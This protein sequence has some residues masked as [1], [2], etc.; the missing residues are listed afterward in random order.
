MAALVQSRANGSTSGATTL[1]LAF[2]NPVTPGNLLICLCG[3][4]AGPTFTM[5]VADSVNITTYNQDVSNAAGGNAAFSINSFPNTAAGTPTVTMTLSSAG[6]RFMI[7]EE[8]SGVISTSPTDKVNNSSGNST[9]PSS[10]NTALLSQANELVIGGLFTASN[11]TQTAGSGFTLD[12]NF[13]GRLAA[14]YQIVASTAAIAATF[15]LAPSDFWQC[16]VAT[17]K[18]AST[19]ATIAWIV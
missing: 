7:I 2:T 6:S 14:E 4:T 3:T 17:Y 16:Q 8:W 18:L 15:G 9:A 19:A 1:A 13:V 5:S 12:P 11:D 10:G